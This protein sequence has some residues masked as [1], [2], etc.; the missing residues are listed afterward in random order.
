MKKEDEFN[1]IPKNY[2]NFYLSYT[3]N[4]EDAGM[5]QEYVEWVLDLVKNHPND[6]NLK[7]PDVANNIGCIFDNGIMVEKNIEF[8]VYWYERAIKLGSV[9]AKS[10]LA[11]I[12]RKGTNGYPKDLAR[13]FEL[14]KS[15][16]LPYAHYRVG[17]FHEYGWVYEKNIEEAKRYYRLAFQ[18]GH[19]LAKKKLATFDFLK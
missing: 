14:Y 2:Q 18:E 5:N 13:A 3:S 7:D 19:C 6:E 10:N 17:E 4:C 1:D 16:G 11:D 12:L 8:A 9:L 15:C